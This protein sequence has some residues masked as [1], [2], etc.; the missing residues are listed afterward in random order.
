ML[1][2]SFP[3]SAQSVW[4]TPS[5]EKR[6][7]LKAAISGDL[8][9]KAQFGAAGLRRVQRVG[10]RLGGVAL[11]HFQQLGNLLVN[12]VRRCDDQPRVKRRDPTAAALPRRRLHGG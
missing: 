7:G 6:M 11:E 10:R 12:V 2:D 8:K 5:G 4:T 3:M 9:L 1:N